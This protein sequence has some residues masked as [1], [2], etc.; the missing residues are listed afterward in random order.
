MD[1]SQMTEE[2]PPTL[3]FEVSSA[4]TLLLMEC[5][6]SQQGG[7]D[8]AWLHDTLL[9]EQLQAAMQLSLEEA[10]G[11]RTEA[12]R[13]EKE[14]RS[15]SA[16]LA[17][18]A[19]NEE[20]RAPSGCVPAALPMPLLVVLPASEPCCRTLRGFRRGRTSFRPPA[21][22]LAVHEKWTVFLVLVLLPRRLPLFVVAVAVTG[23]VAHCCY[24]WREST[25]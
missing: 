21:A 7:W 23:A 19:T 12:H 5:F 14:V 8:R 20:V 17:V 25:H 13:L 10:G 9:K 3:L 24:H 16:C 22:A 2:D 4:S 18:Y 1:I 11:A 15:D 6:M